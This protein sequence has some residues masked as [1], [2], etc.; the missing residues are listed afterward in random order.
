MDETIKGQSNL[1]K[2]LEKIKKIESRYLLFRG[3]SIP[4]TA[5]ITIG[6]SDDNDVVIDDSMASRNHALIQKI[7]NAF[8]LKDLDSTNGTCVND[9]QVPKDKYIKLNPRDVI[10]IGRTEF[11][12]G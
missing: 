6:R 10:K 11:T 12:I 8:F 2:R 4:I 1:G 9:V 3:R 7:E 5:K